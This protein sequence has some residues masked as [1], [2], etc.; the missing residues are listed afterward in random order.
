MISSVVATISGLYMAIPFGIIGQTF[1]QA[2]ADRD[3]LLVMHRT[4]ERLDRWGY[5]SRDIPWLFQQFD[6]NEDKELDVDEFRLMI[7]DMG[8]GLKD[9]RAVE[10][11][12]AFDADSSGSV[13]C[14]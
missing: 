14:E 1:N 8:I 9:E 2:W 3:R 11:F 12:R 10:L 13:D 5:S 6:L 4:R 7:A